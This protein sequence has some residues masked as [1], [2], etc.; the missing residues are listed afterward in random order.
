MYCKEC[1]TENQDDSLR[2]IKCNVYLKSS[3]SPLTGGNR[4]KIISFLHF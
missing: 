2:C 1:G 4:T 3:D